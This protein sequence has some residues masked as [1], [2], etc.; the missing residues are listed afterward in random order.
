MDRSAAL[1]AM[2]IAAVSIKTGRLERGRS[3]RD[4]GVLG[5]T[6]AVDGSLYTQNRW[7]ADRLHHYLELI[8]GRDRA[9]LINVCT[10]NDGSGMGAAILVAAEEQN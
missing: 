2:G 9:R 6:V 8:L 1:A 4:R 10:S 7:Y 5:M 3:S